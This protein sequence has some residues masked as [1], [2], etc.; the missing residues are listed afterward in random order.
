MKDKNFFKNIIF[1][2]IGIIF[3][4]LVLLLYNKS[5]LVLETESK[6]LVSEENTVIEENNIKKNNPKDNTVKTS[7]NEKN[8]EINIEKESVWNDNSMNYS[9]IQIQIKNNS[10]EKLENWKLVVSTNQNLQIVQTWNGNCNIENQNI[11]VNPVEYNSK[12][13]ENSEIKIGGT[14]SYNGDLEFLDYEFFVNDSLLD[15]NKSNNSQNNVQEEIEE[16]KENKNVNYSEIKI[17]ENSPLDI[18]GKLKVDGKNIVD[19]NGNKFQIQGLSTHSIYAFPQ[20]INYNVFKFT[21]EELNSNT[22]RLCVYSNPADG[23]SEN[24][25]TKVDDGVEYATQLGLYVILD[26]HILTDNDPNINKE[27]A[28]KFFSRMSEKYKDYDNIFYEICN[29]PNGNVSWETVKNYAIEMINLIR[30]KDEDSIIIIGTPDYCKD[31]NSVVNSPIKDVD[32]LL[33]SFHFYS[34]S[35]KE[36]LR[37]VVENAYNKNLPIIVSEFGLSEYTGSGKIDEEEAEKWIDFLRNKNI[38]YL[39]WTISSKDES[40]A[41]L[42]TNVLNIDNLTEGDLSQSGLW[43]RYKYNN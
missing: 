39:C 9:T 18:H 38:G 2:C 41:L 14:F 31:L 30:E 25:Y 15:L 12:I 27:S 8:I 34:A 13:E 33:Y 42:K 10:N 36:D 32:N 6:K 29:E 23:Y 11:I 37:D 28:K 21:K 19:N 22:I 3:V 35:H 5:H 17:D 20:F 26:W 24:L 40:S 16:N 7:S 4:I 1:F 43:I